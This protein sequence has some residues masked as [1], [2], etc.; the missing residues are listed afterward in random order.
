MELVHT[1]ST[2]LARADMDGPAGGLMTIL[3]SMAIIYIFVR[4]MKFVQTRLGKK[5]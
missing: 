2:A 3:G 5:S 4:G 1:A